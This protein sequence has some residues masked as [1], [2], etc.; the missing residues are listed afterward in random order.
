MGI[1]QTKKLLQKKKKNLFHSEGN[2]QN[3]RPLK[4]WEKVFS[5]AMSDKGLIL[6]YTKNSYNSTSKKQKTQLKMFRGSE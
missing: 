3:K 1:L 5:N 6:K 4:D 2:W